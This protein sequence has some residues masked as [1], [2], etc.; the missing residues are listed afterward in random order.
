MRTNSTTLQMDLTVNDCLRSADDSKICKQV[1][2]GGKVIQKKV[3]KDI[4]IQV[5]QQN[6]KRNYKTKEDLGK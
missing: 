2:S 1:K 4:Q 3:K 5:A 6:G